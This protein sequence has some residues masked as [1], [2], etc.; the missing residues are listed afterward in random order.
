MQKVNFKKN[1]LKISLICILLISTFVCFYTVRN[2]KSTTNMAQ[3]NQFSGQGSKFNNQN[4]TSTGQRSTENIPSS[5]GE[6]QPNQNGTVAPSN[7]GSKPEQNGN[8]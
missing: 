6:I 8:T 4:N 5:N 3:N 7:D 1:I 2:Y